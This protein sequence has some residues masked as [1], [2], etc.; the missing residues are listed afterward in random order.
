VADS[1]D[2]VGDIV[3]AAWGDLAAW[4]V[5]VRLTSGTLFD[6]SYAH[7]VPGKAV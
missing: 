6:G 4:I 1:S 3:D 5:P 7:V 2:A